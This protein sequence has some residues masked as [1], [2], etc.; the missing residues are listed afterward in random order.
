ML[1]LLYL[2][3]ITKT[4]VY[5]FER[6]ELQQAKTELEQRN[7]TLRVEAARLQSLQRV[8]GSEVAADL[9]EQSELSYLPAE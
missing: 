9:V 8:E 4:S 3:Q 1:G 2:V 5:G 7:E 6:G